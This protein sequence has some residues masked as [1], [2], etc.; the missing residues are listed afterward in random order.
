MT[1]HKLSSGTPVRRVGPAVTL[2]E[3]GAA[4]SDLGLTRPQLVDI[5]F[6]NVIPLVQIG[7][8]SYFNMYWLEKLLFVATSPGHLGFKL[9]SMPP[10][11]EDLKQ[12]LTEEYVAAATTHHAATQE[13]LRARIRSLASGKSC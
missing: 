5:L 4:A 10:L 12:N 11:M 7:R 8:Q 1:Q 9:D 2:V 6:Q 13:Q 3:V